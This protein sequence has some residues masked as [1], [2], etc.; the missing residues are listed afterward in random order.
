MRL[1]ICF[2]LLFVFNLGLKAQQADYIKENYEKKEYE[3]EMRDG[4]RLFTQVY[5]PKDKSR[6]YPFLMQRTCYS[7]RP[8]GEDQYK[9]RLGPSEKLMREGYIFVYQDVRGRYMSEGT[10]D[11]MR[12]NVPGNKKRKGIDESSD[13]Y[14]TIE[15]LLENI[16][17]NNGKVG[18]WGISYPGFYTAAAIPDAHPALKASSPQAP[19]GDFYFDDFHH[20]GALLQSYLVAYPVFGVQKTEKTTK[21]WYGSQFIRERVADAYDWHLDLGPLSNVT[22]KYYK[23]NFFWQ[24]M[25]EHPNYDEF[26]QKRGLIQHLGKIDH[27]V[28]T[29]GGFF[30]AEDLYGPLSIYKKLEKENPDAFNIIVMGPWSHGDWAR[31]RGQQ[32]V[33]HI[34]FGD[35]L[36]TQYQHEVEAEFFN[37]ILKEDRKP[38]LPEAYIFDTGLNKWN[39]FDQWPPASE[40]LRLGFGKDGKLLIN[41]EGSENDVFEY[42]SDPSK[43]V[44]YRSVTEGLTFTPR[45][46]MTDDQRHANRRTD[47]L[48]FSTDI[49]EEDLLLS[50]EL[51]AELDVVLEGIQDADFVVKVIDVFPADHP[52]FEHNDKNIKMGSYQ[53]LVRAEVMRGRYRNGFDKPEPFVEGTVETVD[54]K[55][56]DICHTIKKGHKLMIQI[57]STWFPYIDR[58]PQKYIENIFEA[59]Q[60]DFIKGTIKVLGSSSV[61]LN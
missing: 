36:S 19:I 13:T 12:P 46:Y 60:E 14:D 41:K 61:K 18:Q 52:D 24:Q 44:P 17:G 55:L 25:V 40:S 6:T 54:F 29:V 39:S 11:N 35:S 23:D 47:V 30:D 26:W 5:S 59:E 22:E 31:E 51:M 49:M 42:V 58:N 21:S 37:A 8:Y 15:W 56:Q 53:M 7:V 43:P 48:S 2:C 28:M 50:G 33:N 32:T 57:H 27:S 9:E 3:I 1:S 16:E 10:F 34:Y 45:A 4:V 38:N 20:N